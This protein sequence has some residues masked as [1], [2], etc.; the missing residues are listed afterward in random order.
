MLPQRVFLLTTLALLAFAANSLL[1]RG[2]LQ[3]ELIGPGE[4]AVLRV[5]FGALTLFMLLAWRNKRLPRRQPIAFKGVVGLAAYIVGFS[6]AYV[7]LDAGLGALILFGTVQVVMFIAAAYAGER[8]SIYRWLGALI[9]SLGLLV[10][11][12]PDKNVSLPLSGLILMLLA[13][14]GWALYSLEGR[15]VNDPLLAT[16]WNF[17]YVLPITLLV[18]LTEGGVG[19][20]SGAGASL[21]ITTNGV[22]LALVSG[23]VMSGLGY[24]LWYWVLLKLDVTTGA[25]AQLLVPVFALVL[26]ALFLQETVSLRAAMATA[27]IVGGVAVGSLFKRA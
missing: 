5:A 20:A 4:F 8:L 12:W 27:L 23:S 1:N 15:R 21:H 16:T 24:A 22:L 9:A 13:A 19:E 11:F 17:I 25:L 3:Y 6:Y 26:G 2:A 10:L 18:W 14:F 7:N